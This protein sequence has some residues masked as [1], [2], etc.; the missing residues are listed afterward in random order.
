MQSIQKPSKAASVIYIALLLINNLLA[1]ALLYLPLL[2]LYISPDSS[3]GIWGILLYLIV[4]GIIFTAISYLLTYF[5]K[6]FYFKGLQELKRF[7]FYQFLFFTIVDL[8]FWIKF[9]L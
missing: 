1:L 3:L 2:S 5:F 8:V 4:T 6:K 9:Y 7:A